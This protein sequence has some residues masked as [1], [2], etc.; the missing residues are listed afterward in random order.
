M[1]TINLFLG[2][3]SLIFLFSS[4]YRSN[5]CQCITTDL[6]T[7]QNSISNHMVEGLV[8]LGGGKKAMRLKCKAFEYQDEYSKTTCKITE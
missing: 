7:E 4:C 8:G 1:K 6:Q 3:I 2:V 5:N